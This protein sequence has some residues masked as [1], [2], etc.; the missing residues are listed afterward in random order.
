[1]NERSSVSS[2][3]RGSVSSTDRGSGSGH[4]DSPPPGEGAAVLHQADGHDNH[5]S[6]FIPP[7]EDAL[8]MG[9]NNDEAI[10]ALSSKNHQVLDE[11]A[12]P[13]PARKVQAGNVILPTFQDQVADENGAGLGRPADLGAVEYGVWHHSTPNVQIQT[14]PIN[15]SDEILME[16]NNSE[17][18]R[19]IAETR[20]PNLSF[21]RD[22]FVIRQNIE[23]MNNRRKRR[24]CICFLCGSIAIAFPV[25]IVVFI[26][27]IFLFP[28]L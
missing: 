15:T 26:I 20:H 23:R 18:L 17:I 11:D 2:T 6:D 1:M 16:T 4:T 5:I 13:A 21:S 8:S 25:G 10:H 27:N 3:D 22:P 7:V 14:A 9:D 28:H 12:I 19:R 24:D